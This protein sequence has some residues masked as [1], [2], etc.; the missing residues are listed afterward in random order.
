MSRQQTVKQSTRKSGYY[1]FH[2][3]AIS[4]TRIRVMPH[5]PVATFKA[6]WGKYVFARRLSIIVL[7]SGLIVYAYTQDWFEQSVVKIDGIYDDAMKHFGFV[8]EDIIIEG[9]NHAPLH[10]I[11]SALGVKEGDG[12]LEVDVPALRA[13]IES[14]PWVESAIIQRDFPDTLLIRIVEKKPAALWQYNNKLKMINE[15]G[16]IIDDFVLPEFQNLLIV[17][18]KDGPVHLKSLFAVISKYPKLS[19]QLKAVAYIGNRRWDL[20]Y[21][22]GML[23]KLPEV[24]IQSAVKKL[25]ELDQKHSLLSGQIEVI[26]LRLDDRM[27]LYVS[28]EKAE[29][30][31]M[32]E[33][34]VD[35]GIENHI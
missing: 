28:P 10:T 12:I 4:T 1:S 31:K 5:R 6:Y 21:K 7:L 13:R 14:V 30:K 22:N 11:M 8:I 3:G 20:M 29:K 25:M 2:S 32:Q 9:R 23:I 26:D 27:F 17:I 33:S 35:H 34:A 16:D 18:G 24:S 19:H 15:K